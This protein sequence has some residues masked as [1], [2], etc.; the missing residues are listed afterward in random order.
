M[1]GEIRGSRWSPVSSTSWSA[2]YRQMCPGVWPGVHTTSHL[3]ARQVEVV[4]VIQ[5]H[6]GFGQAEHAEHVGEVA[7]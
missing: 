2:S 5:Q 3:P 7:N 1:F 6:V 4:A